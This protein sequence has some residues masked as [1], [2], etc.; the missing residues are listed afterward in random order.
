[1][2]SIPLYMKG[3]SVSDKL[4]RVFPRHNS[5]C[6]AMFENLFASIA[7]KTYAPGQMGAIKLELGSYSKSSPLRK[8]CSW[9][10]RLF[11]WLRDVSNGNDSWSWR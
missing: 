7:M 2:T 8:D 11:P 9:V 6:Q 1:M 3:E 10:G 5:K 4:L